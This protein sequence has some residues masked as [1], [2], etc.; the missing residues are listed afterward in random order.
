MVKFELAN[1]PDLYSCVVVMMLAI[2]TSLISEALSWIFI[3]RTTEYKDLKKEI[4]T[5]TRKIEKKKLDVAENR[6]AKVSEKK[7][8]GKEAKLK[9]LN[10]LMSKSRMKSTFFIAILMIIFI[11]SLSSAYQVSLCCIEKRLY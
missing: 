10:Q 5:L 9:D 3:Y 7:I 6:A 4:D 1:D 8:Q 11:S 2:F